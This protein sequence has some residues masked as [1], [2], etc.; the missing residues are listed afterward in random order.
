MHRYVLTDYSTHTRKDSDLPHSQA[1]LVSS[2]D[3]ILDSSTPS[4][5]NNAISHQYVRA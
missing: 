1:D 4:E 5:I 2:N 3:L